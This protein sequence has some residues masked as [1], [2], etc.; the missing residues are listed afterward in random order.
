M[1][2]TFIVPL[3]GCVLNINDG[4]GKWDSQM[5]NKGLGKMFRAI[6]GELG[7]PLYLIFSC[8]KAGLLIQCCNIL[9]GSKDLSAA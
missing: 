7:K 3:P 2:H 4:M 9:R 1:H 8:V 5:G 6:E